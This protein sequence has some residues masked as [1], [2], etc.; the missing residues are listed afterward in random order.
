MIRGLAEAIDVAGRVDG[1]VAGAV[2]PGRDRDGGTVRATGVRRVAERI[3]LAVGSEH[4][5]AAPRMTLW[6][7]GRDRDRIRRRR[8]RTIADTVRRADR[9]GVRTAPQPGHAGVRL[10]ARHVN[11]SATRRDAHR[12]TRDRRTVCRRGVPRNRDDSVTQRRVH[13]TRRARHPRRGDRIRR[14]RTGPGAR[15]VLGEDG[16]RVRNPV[17]QAGDRC[18]RLR[19]S[20]VGCR[21]R[22][23]RRDRVA[24]DR[25]AVVIERGLPRH[26]GGARPALRGHTG[27]R[28]GR[29]ERSDGN[30]RS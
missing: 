13:H 1:P 2:D 29:S 4:P 11:H 25:T 21:R 16:E 24:R 6:S 7:H 12:G 23:R 26:E 3:D 19:G 22:R 8:P 9:E 18:A 30:G 28:T 14:L 20:G 5:I 10:R 15:R 17:G 27:R